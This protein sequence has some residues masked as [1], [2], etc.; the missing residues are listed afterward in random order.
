MPE[1]YVSK[2]Q[3]RRSM[4]GYALIV[5]LGLGLL[6]ACFIAGINTGYYSLAAKYYLN[7]LGY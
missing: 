7:K 1:Q 4:V 2:W 3:R 5:G 6:L